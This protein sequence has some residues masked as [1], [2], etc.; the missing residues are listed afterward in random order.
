MKRGLTWLVA[1]PAMLAGSQAAHALAYR[2]AFP[3]AR[4]RVHVLALTG[5]GYL[6]QLPLALAIAGALGLVGL[7][8]A[9]WDAARGRRVRE[10]SPAAFA[11]LPPLAFALQEILELSL[12]TGHLGWRAVA[13]PTFLPG[14]ALQ[15]PFAVLAYVAARLLLRSAVRL[16]RALMRPVRVSPARV[17]SLLSSVVAPQAQP[18]CCGARG[19]PL[20]VGC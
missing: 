3:D 15:L 5:H 18:R 13:A 19:P 6:A 16:G 20:A 10:L 2:I 12:H 9:A 11:L 14:L 8:G 1:V 4:V 17:F 7:A